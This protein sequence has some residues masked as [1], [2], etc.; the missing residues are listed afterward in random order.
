MNALVSTAETEIAALNAACPFELMRFTLT[1]EGPLSASGN[2]PKPREVWQIRRALHPQLN[3]PWLVHPALKN[4]HITAQVPKSGATF[5]AERYDTDAPDA[6][7]H[8]GIPLGGPDRINLCAPIQRNGSEFIPLV[9]SSLYLICGLRIIFLRKEDPGSLIKQGGDIDNRLKTLFDALKIPD[10]GDV[11]E[12]N[13]R[14]PLYTLLE[15]DSLI[16]D[17]AVETD[18]LLTKPDAKANEVH[19]LIQVAVKVLRVRS[20]NMGLVGD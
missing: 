7:Y 6:S 9:R 13:K 3:E 15:S 1:Y 16:S 5:F 18:R 17:V 20:I 12:D 11:P 19:L 8:R 2:K 10:E 4:L 14:E